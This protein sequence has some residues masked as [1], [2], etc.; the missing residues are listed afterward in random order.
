MKL[1]KAIITAM[2]QEAKLIIEKYSLKE[3]EKK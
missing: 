2:E 3:K 1:S